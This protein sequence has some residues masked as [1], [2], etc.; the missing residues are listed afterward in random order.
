M[1][2]VEI[3]PA[4]NGYVVETFQLGQRVEK[5]FTD[6]TKAIEY[7]IEAVNTPE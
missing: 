4:V 2:N 7:A 5:I 3:R 6:A 1:V